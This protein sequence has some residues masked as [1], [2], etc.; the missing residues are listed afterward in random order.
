MTQ[1]KS[2]F[3]ECNNNFRSERWK[4][5]QVFYTS[6]ILPEVPT[7]C[8]DPSSKADPESTP[9]K[10][11]LWTQQIAVAAVL[12]SPQLCQE[13]HHHL[14]PTVSSA[15]ADCQSSLSSNPRWLPSLLQSTNTLKKHTQTYWA[16]ALWPTRPSVYHLSAH[17]WSF[18]LS[19]PRGSFR[20]QRSPTPSLVRNQRDHTLSNQHAGKMLHFLW[21]QWRRCPSIRWH[22]ESRLLVCELIP[23]PK[24]KKMQNK[25]WHKEKVTSSCHREGWQK[26]QWS[27]VTVLPGRVCKSNKIAED[28]VTKSNSYQMEG[29][30]KVTTLTT[31]T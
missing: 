1:C 27:K 29:F 12:N 5:Q 20:P 22:L 28:T 30:A 26:K 7:W 23:W 25:D 13:T 4:L 2:N 31:N 24:H 3:K 16:K 21:L 11:N 8:L 10:K 19:P 17:R 9:R 6:F 18:P 15:H 14:D